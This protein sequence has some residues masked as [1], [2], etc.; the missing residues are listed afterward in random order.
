MGTSKRELEGS[1]ILM[2]KNLWL[3]DSNC[4]KHFIRILKKKNNLIN[5]ANLQD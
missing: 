5:Q 2:E 3:T 4:Y 1:V